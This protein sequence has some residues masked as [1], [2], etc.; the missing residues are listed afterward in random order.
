MRA[1]YSIYRPVGRVYG[2]RRVRM[3]EPRDRTIGRILADKA[4]RIPDQ[5]FLVF[6]GREWTYAQ[7]DAVT[8]GFAEGFRRLGVERGQ[9][10]AL[11]LG[12]CPEILFAIWGLGKLGAVA[13]PLN[14]AAKGDVLDYLVSQSDSVMVCP[15]AQRHDRVV[16]AAALAPQ[17]PTVVD[18]DTLASFADITADRPAGWEEIRSGD[19]HLL[20][21][22]SGTTGP[23]KGV[24]SPHSQGHVVGLQMVTH[25]R[26]TSDDRLFTCLPLFH[27]NALWFSVYAAL[28]AEATLIVSPGFSARRFWQDI[29]DSG[30][31]EFNALGAMANIIWQQPPSELDRQHSVRTALG[32]AA[33][34][35][36]RAAIPRS[37]RHQSHFGVRHDREHRA[38]GARRR[39]TALQGVLCRTRP[40][41]RR[42]PGG[43]RP[44]PSRSPSARSVRSSSG[45]TIPAPSCSVTTACRKPPPRPPGACG[46][47]PAIAAG[48]TRTAYLY[49][50]D[51][52][53]EAIRRRGENISAYEVEVGA[54]QPPGS[55]GGRGR[56]GAV[57]TR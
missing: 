17:R 6:E 49:F 24:I 52:K 9:H 8:N 47:T 40:R 56:A 48:S 16:A 43:G 15:D 36:S 45:P 42:H 10:I 14:T 55:A 19:P 37:V 26:Y 38:D 39:R 31:T 57:R 41:Q 12:N 30:A 18:F 25:C 32:G 35:R 4:E 13:V 46:S 50:S 20:M 22:T 11:V 27:A 23:S 2:G 53:K 51:R 7:L 21:Y 1:G 33:V 29:R 34:H 5:V 44:R 28:W 54:R 3:Y